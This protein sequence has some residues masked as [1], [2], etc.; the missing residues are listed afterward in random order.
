[1]SWNLK[2]LATYDADRSATQYHVKRVDGA[3]ET[4]LCCIQRNWNQSLI[5]GQIATLKQNGNTT[6]EGTLTTYPLQS[7]DE[8]SNALSQMQTDILKDGALST[9]EKSVNIYLIGYL[10]DL[11]SKT[12]TEQNRNYLP[13]FISPTFSED[14]ARFAYT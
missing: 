7:E 3:T 9:I 2:I 13:D 11:L 6:W 5:G 14:S 10:D 4:T 12:Q 8:M 1:M